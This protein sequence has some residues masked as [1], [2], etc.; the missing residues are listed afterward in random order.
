M[1]ILLVAATLPEIEPF[2]L[3][4]PGAGELNGVAIGKHRVELLVSGAGMVATAYALGRHLQNPYDLAI[5]AGI[6]GSFDF[7]LPPGEVCI[8]R[9]DTFAEFGA[10]DGDDFLSAG[11]LGLGTDTFSSCP[12]ANFSIPGLK[13]VNAITVNKVHGNEFSIA[14][15]I[16]RFNP[17]IES[18]EGAAFFY[19]CASA[20]IPCIQIRAISNFV[21]RRN[22]ESWNIPLAV[23]KLNETIIKLLEQ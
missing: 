11:Q 5:N 15:A 13:E 18:M 1:K 19:A 12:P 8:V 7:N 17:Q 3:R 22:R 10:E 20:G 14:K 21:E 16:A 6:A 4:Y 23:G 2:H 9:E